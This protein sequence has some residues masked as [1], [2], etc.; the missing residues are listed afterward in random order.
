MNH[1]EAAKSRGIARDT[2][3]AWIERGH[4]KAEKTDTG[5]TVQPDDLDQVIA[6][7]VTKEGAGT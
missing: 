3:E 6:E 1:I 2:I 7:R 5:F 4:L